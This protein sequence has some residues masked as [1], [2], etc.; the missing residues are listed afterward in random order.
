[1][2]LEFKKK[3]TILRGCVEEDSILFKYHKSF[4]YQIKEFDFDNNMSATRKPHS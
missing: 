2:S 4:V 1:M 3:V